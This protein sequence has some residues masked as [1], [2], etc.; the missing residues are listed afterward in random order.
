MKENSE[1][2][3]ET[4]YRLKLEETEQRMGEENAYLRECMFKLH[5]Q[6]ESAKNNGS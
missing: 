2:Q 6:L 5:E 3:G 4:D 1:G